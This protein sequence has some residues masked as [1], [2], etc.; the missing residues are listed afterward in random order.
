VTPMVVEQARAASSALGYAG[1]A[2]PGTG[3]VPAA[4]ERKRASE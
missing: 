1:E 2:A 3:P 4:R